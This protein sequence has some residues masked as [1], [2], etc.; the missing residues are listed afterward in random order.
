MVQERNFVAV[1]KNAL[2]SQILR[3]LFKK[4]YI[5]SKFARLFCWYFLV[6]NNWLQ[7]LPGDFTSRKHLKNCYFSARFIRE[8][9]DFEMTVINYS[10][11]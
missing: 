9:R 10:D 3:L 7:L 1:P 8:C 6:E 2:F 4:I 5:G 11:I